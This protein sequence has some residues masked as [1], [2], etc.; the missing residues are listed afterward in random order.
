M[1]A[2][3]RRPARTLIALSVAAYAAL[4]AL[5][6]SLPAPAWAQATAA[7]ASQ[8]YE[9]ALQRF[10]K[11]DYAGAVVQLK[12]VLRLEPKNLSAQV[13]L[14]RA[15]LVEGQAG[16][17]EV[18][19]DEALRLGVDRS[20]VVVPLARAMVAQGKQG[21]LASDRRLLLDGLAAPLRSALLLLRASAQ[22]DIG[23]SKA[24]LRSIEEARALDPRS[25]DSWIAEVPVRIRARQST[26]A[27]AAARRAIELSADSADAHYALGSA[28]HSRGD[29]KAAQAGYDRALTLLPTHQDALVA[30]AGLLID[31]AQQPAARRD[32]EALRKAAPKDPRGAYLKALLDEQAGATAAARTALREVTELLDPIPME[33]LRFRPQVLMLGGLAH[34]GLNQ[35]EKAKPYLE[36][37]QRLQP[38]SPVSK[39][40]AQIYLADRNVDRAI[41]SLESYLRGQ[42]GDRQALLLLASAHA[43]QGRHSRSAQLMTEALKAGDAPDMRAVLGLSLLGTG[44]VVD[45]VKELEAAFA[46]DPGQVQ[47]GSALVMLYLQSSQQSKAVAVA[48]RLVQRQPRDAGLQNLL[49]M[50]T[51][52]RGDVKAARAAFETALKLDPR[53][54]TPQVQLARLDARAGQIDAAS[55]RLNAVLATDPRHVEAL[56]ELATMLEARRQL[57][58]AALALRKAAEAS[59][60]TQLGPSLALVD[61]H[62][63]HN[64]AKAARQASDYLTARAPEAV[65]VLLALAQIALAHGEVDAAKSSLSRASRLSDYQPPVLLKIAT[66]QNQAGAPADAA[67]TLN[68]ALSERPDFLPAQALLAEVELRQGDFAKAEARARQLVARHPKE[69][70]GHALLGDAARARGQPAAALEHYRRAHQIEPGTDSLLRLFAAQAISDPRGAVSLAEDWVR[71]QPQDVVIRRVLGDAHARLGQFPQARAHYEAALKAAPDEVDVLNNLA[72]VMILQKDPAALAVAERALAKAPG[73]PRLIGTAG[74]AAFH[75]G[76]N[77]RALQ[78]LREARLRDPNNPDTRYFLGSALARQGRAAE[79]REELRGALASGRAFTHAD[80]A[81]RLLKTLN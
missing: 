42:P 3:R 60:P 66:L 20:E 71:R 11:K 68:K 73:L 2:A 5:P 14:G 67:H 69:P 19:F 7:R 36:A 52:A 22:A 62:L 31:L 38:S 40:L 41:E 63:R 17:A 37:V 15:L 35:R 32:V 29:L 54:A 30:R 34:Y 33:A 65:P 57:P 9:D 1:P 24:A 18:A 55:A 74:W 27:I 4:V 8:F 10:E 81:E 47:A 59:G 72:N 53:F 64:D 6:A 44:K 50:A 75:A 58:E 56:S 79:A 21:L 46:R 23:D 51:A 78:L 26:E 16:A 80:D 12:N 43:S 76:Q 61:F 45:A 77:D 28:H 25:A 39:L 70:V 49:G 13:L 48:Q